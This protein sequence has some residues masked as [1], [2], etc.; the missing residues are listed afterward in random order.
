MEDN[1]Q[2]GFAAGRR[3]GY[4]ATKTAGDCSISVPMEPLEEASAHQREVAS[5]AVQHFYYSSTDVK[6]GYVGVSV[7]VLSRLDSFHRR[8]LRSLIG[9]KWPQIIPNDALYAR[10]EAESL[11]VMVKRS[12]WRLF[13][14]PAIM[15]MFAY[16]AN[17]QQQCWRGRPRTTLPQALVGDLRQANAGLL[18]NLDALQRLRAIAHDRPAWRDLCMKICAS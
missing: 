13:E 4:Y 7:T 6:L 2:A 14:S 18:G 1:A 5:A 15:A 8:Q 12:R 16:F 10:C 11:S 3:R 17:Q 9:V